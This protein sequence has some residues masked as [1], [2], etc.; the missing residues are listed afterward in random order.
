MP[1]VVVQISR[2]MAPA[3]SIAAAVEQAYRRGAQYTL[4][5]G[6]PAAEAK[7][8]AIEVA[9][10]A[11]ADLVLVE[12]DVLA[13][14]GIW[15]AAIAGSA[16]VGYCEATCRDGR[17][18]TYR[19]PTGRF[20]A[21]G[22]VLV[23]LSLSVLIRLRDEANALPLEG[24]EFARHGDD[25]VPVVRDAFGRGSDM[26][27]WYN[28]AQKLGYDPVRLGK[29]TSIMHPYNDGVR[30]DLNAPQQFRYT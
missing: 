1:T 14:D 28:V 10:A 27:L 2:G 19:R 21:S 12:D 13:D 11:S 4:V 7:T 20:V 5:S 26:W 15:E 3:E 9:L 30:H 22:T 6:K 24:W 29:V 23:R 18:N 17:S 8:A 25:L 16:A